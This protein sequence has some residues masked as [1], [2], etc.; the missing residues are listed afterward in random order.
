MSVIISLLLDF[1][2]CY[3]RDILLRRMVVATCMS[4]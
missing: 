4:K 1:H 2:S 3:A